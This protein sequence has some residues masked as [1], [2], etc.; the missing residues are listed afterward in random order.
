MNHKSDKHS[1]QYVDGEVHTNTLEGFW[2]LL[3]RAWYGQHH[4][5]L[6]L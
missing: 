3:K 1:E 5:F 2:S 4:K 6:P